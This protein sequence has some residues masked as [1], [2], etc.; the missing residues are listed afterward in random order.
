MATLDE[1]VTRAEFGELQ[2]VVQAQT[3]ILGE[4]VV[5]TKALNRKVDRLEQDMAGLKEDVKSL[6]TD[7]KEILNRLP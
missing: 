7:V 3:E 2:N 5:G 4:I 6:K 1:Q